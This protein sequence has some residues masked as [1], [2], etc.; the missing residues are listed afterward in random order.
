MSNF[1]TP[2][3]KSFNIKAY[4]QVD[5]TVGTMSTQRVSDTEVNSTPSVSAS[6]FK[7]KEQRNEDL[8]EFK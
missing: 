1:T 7:V 5:Q 6:S 3:L 2:I 8:P 4:I